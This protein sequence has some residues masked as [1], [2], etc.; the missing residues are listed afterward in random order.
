VI[1]I[2]TTGTRG[3]VQPYLALGNELKKTGYRVRVAA[4]ENYEALVKEQG[5]EYFPVKG[6]VTAAASSVDGQE[7]MKADNPLKFILSFS[8]LKKLVNDLQS[9]FY[10]ACIDSEAI[11]YHPGAPI[12]YFAAQRL[13]IPSILATPFP[14]A[15][16][17]ERPS[18]IFYNSPHLGGTVNLL[19]HKVL[20]QVMWFASG[21]AIKQ[22]WRSKFKETPPDFGCPFLRQTSAQQPTIIS[23]SN[24]I[25]PKPGDWPE[26]VNNTGY[27][28]LGDAGDLPSDELV[29]FL[30]QGEAPVYVGF[31]SIG[32]PTRAAITTKLVA[33]ALR[34]SGRRGI[35]Q[36]GWG[37]L[38]KNV[39]SNPDVLI[40]ESAP[41]AWLFPRV[42]AV[43]HHGGA[44]TT[45]TG[46]FA[47]VPNVV[48]PSGNDQIAWGKRVSELG[49]GPEPIPSSRLSSRRLAEA[50]RYAS[51]G[52]VQLN[53][54]RLGLLIQSEDGVKTATMIIGSCIH[55][56]ELSLTH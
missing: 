3:D 1:T 26:H 35:L 42:A 24:H 4:F 16:T 21:S 5:L 9:D 22:F 12:G 51:R 48:V 15:P 44:G 38:S 14:M 18:L 11:I 31:G 41:H 49:V 6:D 32:D 27:W 10:E 17:R 55:A 33:E 20:E 39:S 34:L 7:A 46:L 52:D 47:G 29:N 50:I 30:G 23:C 37:G 13:K 43:V 54:K 25:F 56:N 19:T 8:K 45:H 28:F 40:V 53:A 2:L 36:T